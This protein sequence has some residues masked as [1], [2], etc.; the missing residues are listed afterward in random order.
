M[1][2]RIEKTMSALERNNMR[3]LYAEN[4]AEARALVQE[5]LFKGAVIASG[6]SVSLKQSGVWDI[7][8]SPDYNFLDRTKP[9]L[10]EE[11]KLDIFRATIG[12]D[13]Y[14]CS[15]NAVT[16][17]GE[18]IN[19]DG[20]ANRISAISFGPKKVI[21]LVGVNKLVKDVNEGLLRVKRIAAPKNT[22]RLEIDAPCRKYGRCISLCGSE[23]PNITDG[24]GGDTRICCD[25]LISA[26]QRIHNRINVILC[27]EELGY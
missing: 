8:G 17:N 12:C 23:C 3:A 10:T 11:E 20:F 13:F 15:S 14:F 5:M 6:G 25:Y 26:R 16:E 22:A 4:C 2:E 7:I 27:N 18:L 9:G 1:N 21:M 19:V 24:C